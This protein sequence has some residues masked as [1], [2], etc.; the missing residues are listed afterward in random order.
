MLPAIFVGSNVIGIV[1][2]RFGNILMKNGMEL[3]VEP[4]QAAG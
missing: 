2:A 1:R 3:V 4:D